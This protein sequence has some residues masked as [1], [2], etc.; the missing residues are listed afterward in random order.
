VFVEVAHRKSFRAA[1]DSS[2]PGQPG[3]SQ[4][5]ARPES[6]LGVK[7]FERNTRAVSLTTVGEM[8]L[9]DTERVLADPDRSVD[10]LGAFVRG[11]KRRVRVACLSSSVFRLLPGALD[12]MATLH[13]AFAILLCDDNVRAESA[14]P[15]SMARRSTRGHSFSPEPSSTSCATA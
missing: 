10:R 3:V 5:I 7:L 2:S 15:M 13:P 9:A 1:A 4:A 12:A 14:S 8:L 6:A 11:G